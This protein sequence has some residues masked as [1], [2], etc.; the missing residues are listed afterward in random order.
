MRIAVPAPAVL[1]PS[2]TQGGGGERISGSRGKHRGPRPAAR[3]AGSSNSAPPPSPGGRKGGGGQCKPGGQGCGCRGLGGLGCRGLWPWSQ[4]Q[5]P[6]RNFSARVARP[7]RPPRWRGGVN[8]REKQ[9]ARSAG[10]AG[11]SPPNS[12]TSPPSPSAQ[13]A[14][15][16]VRWGGERHLT[17]T[18][19]PLERSHSVANCE[20][21]CYKE[22]GHLFLVKKKIL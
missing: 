1:Q 7:A 2:R 6:R 15:G 22:I 16:S 20:L 17:A 11:E 18:R 3:T 12:S 4:S 10:R 13:W 21:S 9:H 5:S 19:P 14:A 8:R